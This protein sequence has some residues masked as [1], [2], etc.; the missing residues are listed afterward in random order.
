[1]LG[2]LDVFLRSCCDEITRY[3]EARTQTSGHSPE[4]HRTG[5]AAGSLLAGETEEDRISSPRA[6]EILEKEIS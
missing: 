4:D 6:A 1:M 5:G 2:G 3:S